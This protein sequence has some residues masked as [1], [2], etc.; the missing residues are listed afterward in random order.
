MIQVEE[1]SK[2]YNIILDS[3]DLSQVSPK[4]GVTLTTQTLNGMKT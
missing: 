4:Y 2:E 3:Y 1:I